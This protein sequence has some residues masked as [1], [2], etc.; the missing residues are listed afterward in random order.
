MAPQIMS[1]DQRA[2]VAPARRAVLATMSPNGRPRLVPICFVLAGP[3][4]ADALERPR[5]YTPIDEKPKATSNPHELGRVQDLLVLP[6]ATVLVDRWS[7]DWSRLGWVRL[8]AVGEILEPQPQER[9]E[10]A[11]VVDDLRAKYEQYRDQHLN[12]RPI[13][14]LTVTAAVSWGDLAPPQG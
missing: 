11:A 5:L 6:Q 8:Q 3:E 4:R 2:F 13:I 14:R 1:D 10:H 9:E 12:D 7:E